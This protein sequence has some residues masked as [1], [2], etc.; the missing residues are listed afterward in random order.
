MKIFLVRHAEGEN[1]G[2]NWQTPMTTLSLRG[3]K[4]AEILAERISRFKVIDVIITSDWIRSLQT[5]EIVGKALNKPVKVVEKIH[6]RQ[7]S[8][9]IYGL[10]RNVPLAKQYWLDLSK[11]RNDWNYKWDKEEESLAELTKR[12][13]D[14]QKQLIK[15]YSQKS[16][17]VVSHESFLSGLVTACLLGVKFNNNYFKNLFNS[18]VIENTGLSLLIYREEQK[19]WKLW[20]LNDYS[21][22]RSL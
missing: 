2:L 18:I 11:N 10:P 6:E 20:Y 17:L 19:T 14:F 3:V 22:R 12:I 21:H 4:Q 5:A 16:V 9:R 15:N 13:I 7:Q 1:T 8:S